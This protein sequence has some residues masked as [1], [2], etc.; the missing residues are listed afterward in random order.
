LARKLQCCLLVRLVIAL[1][2]LS[3]PSLSWAEDQVLLQE[4]LPA[5]QG[6]ELG[7]VVV[8]PAPPPGAT[9]VVHGSDIRRALRSVGA[10]TKGLTIPASTPVQRKLVRL[11]PAALTDEASALI[12][13]AAAPCAVQ[14]AQV[15]AEAR[16]TDGERSLR[17]ELPATLRSGHVGGSLVID[18]AGRQTRVPLSATLQCPEPT[19]NA[20]QEIVLA[21]VIGQVMASAPG[22]AKQAGRVGDVIRVVNRAT[23]AALR[24]RIRDAQTAEIVQ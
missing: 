4:V 18:N 17:V 8:A 11:S 3:L 14:S 13:E 7:R 22:E 23:G 9:L 15:T 2:L 5:L 20:G 1:C 24:A 6:S 21:V 19:M 12:E 10:S 16:I